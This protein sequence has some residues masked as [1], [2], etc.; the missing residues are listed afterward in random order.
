V[1]G[2]EMDTSYTLHLKTDL[3]KFLNKIIIAV[4]INYN[5]DVRIRTN[6]RKLEG[7]FEVSN[8]FKF[9]SIR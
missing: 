6:R 2:Q 1:L 4:V 3:L 8:Q 5:V 7:R 9:I